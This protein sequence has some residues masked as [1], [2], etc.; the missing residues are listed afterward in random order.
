MAPHINEDLTPYSVF[1]FYFASHITVSGGDQS[2][3]DQ[4]YLD[5]LDNRP[6]PVP[7]ITGSEMFLVI[8]IQ[9]DMI[10]VTT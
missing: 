7:H 2:I 1:I 4:Q 6:S 5:F 8:I 10:N 3:Y 9:M